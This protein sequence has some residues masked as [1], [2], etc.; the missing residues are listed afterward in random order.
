MKKKN[1]EFLRR[2]HEKLLTKNGILPPEE[3]TE[4][5]SLPGLVASA[6]KVNGVGQ[7]PPPEVFK[8]SSVEHPLI[9]PISIM[10]GLSLP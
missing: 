4:R 7:S 8:E 2:K 6:A 1:T 10:K 9:F 3:T 5:G